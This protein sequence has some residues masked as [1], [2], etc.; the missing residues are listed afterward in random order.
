MRSHS[1]GFH[2]TVAHFAFCFRE[3]ARRLAE[4]V[5]EARGARRARS[6]TLPWFRF[7]FFMPAPH[8]RMYVDRPECR[9]AGKKTG[10][11]PPDAAAI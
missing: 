4:K 9:G 1:T 2:S 7:F 10:G 6:S 8:P 3:P 5:R 11:L